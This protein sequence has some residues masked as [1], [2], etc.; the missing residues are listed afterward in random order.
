MEY[1]GGGGKGLT[2]KPICLFEKGA[3]H[4]ALFV[5]TYYIVMSGSVL[6]SREN[7]QA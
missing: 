2:F 3:V 7:F 4:E 1:G 5:F 6:D